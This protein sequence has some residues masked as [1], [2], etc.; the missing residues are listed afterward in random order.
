MV[1][2]ANV[3]C[4]EKLAMVMGENAKANG[5][6]YDHTIDGGR[7]SGLTILLEDAPHQSE[8]NMSE[9]IGTYGDPRLKFFGFACIIEEKP[10]A[11]L[12]IDLALAGRR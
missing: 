1:S 12:A 6:I 5:V 10:K 7:E 8:L 11:G 9:L 4:E 3:R 2:L